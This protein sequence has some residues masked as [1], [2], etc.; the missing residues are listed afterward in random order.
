MT[1]AP[2]FGLG[3]P[4]TLENYTRAFDPLYGGVPAAVLSCWRGFPRCSAS[5]WPPAASSLARGTA[6][7]IYLNLVDPTLLDQ[8]SGPHL[9]LDLPAARHRP[10]QCHP[11]KTRPD[12]RTAADALQ[13][14]SRD[15]GLVYGYLPFM[16]LPLTPRSNGSTRSSLRPRPPGR[17]AHDHLLARHPAA[18]LSRNS[19]RRRAGLHPLPSEPSSCLTCWEGGK[20]IM[21][22]N[23][24]QN[25]FTTGAGLALRLRALTRV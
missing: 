16:V 21:I 3:P 10:D 12:P 5:H 25:Q 9:R 2:Y 24:V 8:L 11:A 1:A 20:S 7:H 19:R 14:R 23:I 6:P 22:G 17:A 4:W 15:P 18:V 13:R